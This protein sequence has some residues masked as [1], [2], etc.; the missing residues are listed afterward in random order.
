MVIACLV[1]VK[2]QRRRSQQLVA[3]PKRVLRRVDLDFDLMPH[4]LVG[5]FFLWVYRG[6]LGANLCRRG[7]IH[8]GGLRVGGVEQT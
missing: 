7:P 5:L 2:P 1:G 3:R 4:N 6:A 8:S